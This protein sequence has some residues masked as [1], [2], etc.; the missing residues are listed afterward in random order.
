MSNKGDERKKDWPNH[1]VLT[2]SIRMGSVI[3]FNNMCVWSRT[4][5]GRLTFP[6]KRQQP[7]K[8]K[9]STKISRIF[10]LPSF[11]SNQKL[12]LIGSG[13]VLVKNSI[14]FPVHD[15]FAFCYIY[16]N[17]LKCRLL[18]YQKKESSS[19]W[20]FLI[21]ISIFVSTNIFVGRR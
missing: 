16:I 7:S 20:E 17:H 3:T 2:S 12:E 5:I 8:V 15:A 14:V 6:W 10:F 1:S 18:R 13:D 19:S 4:E 21:F 11:K 9:T